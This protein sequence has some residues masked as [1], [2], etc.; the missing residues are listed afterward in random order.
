MSSNPFLRITDA[1][2]G[3]STSSEL[4]D[5]L[6]ALFP[7]SPHRDLHKG[8]WLFRESEPLH[9]LYVLEEGQVSLSK[10]IRGEETVFHSD[11]VGNLIGLMSLTSDDPRSYFSCRANQHSRLICFSH[12]DLRQAMSSDHDLV[13]LFLR[14]LVMAAT[15][16]NRHS[17][18]RHTEVQHLN[19]LLAEERD[20]LAQTLHELNNTQMKLVQA[21]KLATLGQLVAGIAHELNN[22]TAAIQRAASYVQENIPALTRDHPDHEL[23]QRFAGRFDTQRPLSS[24]EQR[25][26]RKILE[27]NGLDND[28]ARRFVSMGL[29]DP[30][31]VQ[32][33]LRSSKDR[34]KRLQDLETLS[35]IYSFL[36]NIHSGSERIGQLVSSLRSYARSGTTPQDGVNVY[37]GLEET[38]TLL[39][40]RMSNVELERQYE[41]LPLIT[42]IPGEINQ[43]W[44]NL[45][46]NAIQAM[47]GR[48]RLILHARVEDPWLRISIEDSGPGISAEHRARIFEINFTTKQ[49]KGDYGI[50]LGLPIC[51]QIIEQ[52]NGR[53]ELES[54]PGRTRFDVFLPLDSPGVPS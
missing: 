46:T 52:H 4:T 44:T 23:L 18:D 35:E 41:D 7:H 3:K 48:G 19:S 54:Q 20:T 10:N 34:E 43:V 16:R 32:E 38:L 22:P 6:Q 39:G 1:D 11:S 33:L 26:A 28:T 13:N 14:T 27:T 8:E 49:G 50:G 53:L 21:E 9:I 12:E 24:R 36:R 30:I 42:C 25:S 5:R 47:D 40:H 15:R 31:E 45:I 17:V 2:T 51:K 29:T 37:T